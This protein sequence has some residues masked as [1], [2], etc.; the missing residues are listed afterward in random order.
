MS[1]VWELGLRPEVFEQPINQAIFNFS[2]EY[3][4]TNDMS[5]VPTKVVLEHEFPGTALDDVVEESVIWLV[6]ALQR[7]YAT[8]QLQEMIHDAAVTSVEDPSGTLK[9]LCDTTYAAVEVITPRYARTNLATSVD[10]RRRRYGERG[11]N[12]GAGVTLGLAALDH[13]TNGLRAGELCA[14]GAFSKVGKTVFLVHAAVQARRQGL[15][16]YFATLEMSTAEIEDRCDALFSSVSYNRLTHGE[17]LADEM[18][19]LVLAQDEL[20]TL[21]NFFVETPDEGER[22]VRSIV[23]RARHLGCDYL[24]VDQLSFMES[25]TN[26]RDLKYKHAEIISNLKREVARESAGM[27]PCLLA[28]QLNRASQTEGIALQSFANAAEIEQTVDLALGLS[29]TREERA[30]KV[31]RL[32]VLG[33]RRSDLRSWLLHW[34][35][36]QRSVIE[37]LQEIE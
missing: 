25:N 24:I 2:V 29:R 12:R 10:E 36:S 13:H 22:T 15:T 5:M 27:L 8:N 6:E 37:I 1:R 26:H 17:L 18:R 4:H 28:V 7:R 30:N 11:D 14:V 19:T 34:E 9:A 16:P 23:N 21:G 3:W 32:D 33:A 35:L 20:A 31:M